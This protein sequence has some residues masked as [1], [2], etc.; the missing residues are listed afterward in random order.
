MPIQIDYQEH[1]VRPREGETV[2]DALLR[3]GVEMP[4]SCKGGVCHTCLLQCTEGPVEPSAQ[5][6]APNCA[7]CPSGSPLR[8]RRGGA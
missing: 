1:R 6:P 2:L 5:P 4:F 8:A 3:Q 7:S